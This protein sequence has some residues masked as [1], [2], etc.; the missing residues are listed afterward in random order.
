MRILATLS[1][2]VYSTLC[3]GV[4]NVFFTGTLIATPTCTVSNQ[5]K[6]IDVTFDTLAINKI[7]GERYRQVIPY[8]VSCPDITEGVAWRMKLT[9]KGFTEFDP[10]VLQTSVA[11]LGIQILLNGKAMTINQAV[12]INISSITTLPELVAIPIKKFGA[13]LP[14]AEF[15]ASALLLAELY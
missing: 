10:A 11:G 13:V 12:P 1:I 6:R 9:V 4:D 8:Q 2:S 14:G 7:D 15:T 5:N 3:I